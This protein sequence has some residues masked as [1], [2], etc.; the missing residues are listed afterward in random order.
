MKNRLDSKLAQYDQ[1]HL[2]KFWDELTPAQQQKLA[3]QIDAIDFE[4]VQSL[5]ADKSADA[6]SDDTAMRAEVPPAITLD[7]FADSASYESAVAVGRKALAGGELAMILV[8]GGQGSRLGFDHP[9]GMYPVGPVSNV[10]LYQI[11]FEK[12][13]A[14]AKQFG[15][16][17]PMY[18]MTSPPTHEETSAFLKEHNF[19]G[20]NSDHVRIFCQGVMPAVDDGGKLLLAAKDE[21]FVSPNGHGGTLAGLVDSGCLQH[22]R[23]LGVKHLFYGQVDNP[24][25]QICD[26]ALVGYHIQ[27]ESQ[28]TSQV[29]RKNDPMQKVGNVVE[30]DGKVQIIEYSD[31]PEAAARL[32]DAEGNLKLWAGSIAVHVFD[33]A[34]LEQSSGQ[35]ETLALSSGS[36]KS[37]FR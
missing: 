3:D 24:L 17:V 12:V 20:M 13:M 28:M 21:V 15:A 27:S 32:T 7:D 2:L 8:A 36:Q 19:F 22:A 26:P 1:T 25:V 30:V 18:V 35:A 29:V 16:P 4:L 37:A 33:L 6:S 5:F 23:D 14:R 9:K 10:S 11:H 34:F 31:L